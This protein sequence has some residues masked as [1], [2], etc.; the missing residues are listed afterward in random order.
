[1]PLKA[2]TFEDCEIFAEAIRARDQETSE[3]L[4]LDPKILLWWGVKNSAEAWAGYDEGRPVCLFGV[5]SPCMLLGT[6]NIWFLGTDEVRGLKFARESRKFMLGLQQRYSN[7][8]GHVDVT[9]D[10]SIRWLEWLGFKIGE[11]TVKAT[12]IVRRF[13]WE[14]C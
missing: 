8:S 2:A 1:M 3:R 7:L 5:D 14:G 10:K 9:F 6:A 12:T 13:Y 4:G 11:E